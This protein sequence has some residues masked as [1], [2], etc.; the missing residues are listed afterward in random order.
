MRPTFL[1]FETQRTALNI[2]QK[3][4]D[5][6]GSN[7]TNSNTEGFSRQR[8]D[9]VSI[10]AENLGIR[11]SNKLAMRGMGADATGVAQYRDA[12][13]DRR[14]RE[15]TSEASAAGTTASVLTSVEDVFNEIN[16]NE[17]GFMYSLL[18]FQKALSN[19]SSD[20]ADRMEVANVALN[21]AQ[22]LISIMR[23][24]STKIDTIAELTYSETNDDVE[25]VNAILRQIG[26]LNKGI[27]ESYITNNDIFVEDNQYHVNETYGPLELKDQRN[28][29][30]D[31]LSEYVDIRYGDN[32]NGSV[33]I[34]MSGTSEGVRVLDD[35]Q[36][37][38]LTL[39]RVHDSADKD[40]NATATGA[41]T[42]YTSLGQLIITATDY[43]GRAYPVD[44]DI[45]SGTLKGYLDTYN[46]KG[47]YAKELNIDLSAT[48]MVK[49]QGNLSTFNTSTSLTYKESEFNGIQYYKDV[50]NTLAM[51]IKREFN[52]AAGYVDQSTGMMISADGTDRALFTGTSIADLAVSDKWRTNPL[53]IAS[54]SV[55]S[56][57]AS[58]NL[59]VNVNGTNHP[60]LADVFYV[61]LDD[62]TGFY[63][64]Q[65]KTG[66]DVTYTNL[67]TNTVYNSDQIASFR[68]AA[69]TDGDGSADAYGDY[70]LTEKPSTGT[71]L[72]NTQIAKLL[73]VFD[74]EFPFGNEPGT[75]TIEGY[76]V[77]FSGKIGSQI[78]YYEDSFSASETM[79][80][81]TYESRDGIMGVS[82]DEE[83]IN[84]LN[85]QKW[86]NASA[87]MV[88]V[89][90][91]ALDT[92]IN[93]MGLVG[94]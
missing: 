9:F 22:S 71:E 48:E 86:Y 35:Q 11:Y 12:A 41:D 60:Q 42:E 19:F 8:V 52:L 89:L 39:S 55:L 33:W 92:I 82:L 6:T 94:R 93:S 4:L 14:F 29:L 46:G 77:Y 27:E 57:D 68:P 62:G 78:K 59:N 73:S 30:L 15:V 18:E 84:M 51:T 17:S 23:S 38:Q 13:L 1:G 47:A 3:A 76:H 7:I 54:Q 20:N 37:S 72:D 66:T 34:E 64:K 87:R 49:T 26:E 10:T 40:P 63:A 81:T 32:A 88:T 25:R 5:I 43:K 74:K 50:I 16:S 53:S 70:I 91:E 28:M 85:F 36:Y 31:E 56:Q 44:M 58:G 61:T 83:G 2:A 45:K 65:D 69:D 90:D 24:Y 79:L 67:T 75:Y 80:N 21:S